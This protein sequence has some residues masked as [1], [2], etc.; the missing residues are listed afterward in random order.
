MN[1]T[2]ALIAGAAVAGLMAGSLPVAPMQQHLHPSWSLSQTMGEKGAH[3]RDR[4]PVRPGGCKSGD[5]GCGKNTCKGKAAA[6]LS[7]KH[8]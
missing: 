8:K 2:K 3:A 4:M 1:T 6:P 7:G 5:Q